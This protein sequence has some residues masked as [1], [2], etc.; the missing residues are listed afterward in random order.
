M[1]GKLIILMYRLWLHGLY[2]LYGPRCPLS[3]KR[4]INL[5][6]LSLSWTTLLMTERA[7]WVSLCQP[8]C[9]LS[10]T[11]LKIAD[12]SLVSI[13]PR[14]LYIE[15][16]YIY[17]YL[18][19]WCITIVVPQV[20]LFKKLLFFYT[21]VFSI[22][23]WRCPS[24]RPSVRLLA[25]KNIDANGGF[26]FKFCTQVCLGVPSI[27]LL[28]VLS[29]LIKYAH[30]SIISVKMSSMSPGKVSFLLSQN[31]EV[32]WW[33][34]APLP[35]KCAILRWSNKGPATIF[36]CMRERRHQRQCPDV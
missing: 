22:M 26:F 6:S 24:V 15:L 17:L 32:I 3:P 18:P 21:P 14:I 11:N 25:R 35:L 19:V 23:V 7:L 1:W 9:V 20:P 4:P 31:L 27:D 13:D 10:I 2:G 16:L 29:F 34:S 12:K 36:T 33:A 8:I 28:S 5:F 30:N